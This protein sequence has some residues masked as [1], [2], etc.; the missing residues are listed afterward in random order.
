MR[1]THSTPTPSQPDPLDGISAL[2]HSAGV[3][4]YVYFIKIRRG[5]AFR[6]SMTAGRARDAGVA[7]AAHGRVR[8]M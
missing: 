4:I 7:S 1:E 6:V 5:V 8:Y 3:T 2:L